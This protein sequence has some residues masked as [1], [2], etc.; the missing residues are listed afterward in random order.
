MIPAHIKKEMIEQLSKYPQTGDPIMN[1]DIYEKLFKLIFDLNE[2]YPKELLTGSK[3][4]L[5]LSFIG[6]YGLGS[7]PE[8]ILKCLA[9]SDEFQKI[10][11]EIDNGINEE[12]SKLKETP[13]TSMFPNIS[14]N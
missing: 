2:Q 3:L 7:I 13:L 8:L 5:I 12:K 6:K 9:N 1:V 4:Y 14:Q 11:D 10:I